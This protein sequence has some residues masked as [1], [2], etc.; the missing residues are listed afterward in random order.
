MLGQ[1][2]LSINKIRMEFAGAKS[3][4]SEHDKYYIHKCKCCEHNF[5]I[6]VTSV[7]SSVACVGGTGERDLYR[8][9]EKLGS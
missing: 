3:Y 5:V 6:M 2:E 7:V 8:C 1:K 9:R 4:S